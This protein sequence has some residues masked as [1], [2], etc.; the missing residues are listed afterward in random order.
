MV[1]VGRTGIGSMDGVVVEGGGDFFDDDNGAAVLGSAVL[2]L[3][4]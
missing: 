3:T 2:A 4:V 1:F